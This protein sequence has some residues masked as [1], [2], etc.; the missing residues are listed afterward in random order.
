MI[1]KKK[2]EVLSSKVNSLDEENL[3]AFIESLQDKIN[4]TIDTTTLETESLKKAKKILKDLINTLKTQVGMEKTLNDLN[5][6]QLL[7]LKHKL[8][9]ANSLANELNTALKAQDH[10][11]ASIVCEKN[12]HK[13]TKSKEVIKI[14]KDEN[15]YFTPYNGTI[16]YIETPK[17]FL[18]KRCT[19]CGLT[20]TIEMVSKSKTLT[21]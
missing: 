1:N 7:D 3:I 4:E 2:I 12:G 11:Y 14:V 10:E 19:R 8:I 6:F 17:S 13:F 9:F 5:L 21:L 15:P 18:E 16:P 20:E